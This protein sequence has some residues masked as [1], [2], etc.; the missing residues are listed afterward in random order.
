MG[1]GRIKGENGENGNVARVARRQTRDAFL[2]MQVGADNPGRMKR[3]RDVE[4][5][6]WR[7]ECMLSQG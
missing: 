4:A 2:T 6:R 5:I 7:T 3:E 1:D